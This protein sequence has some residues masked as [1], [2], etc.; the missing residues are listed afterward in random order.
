[1]SLKRFFSAV[2]RKWNRTIFCGLSS[3]SCTDSYLFWSFN[4]GVAIEGKG[5]LLPGFLFSFGQEDFYQSK[6]GGKH[7]RFFFSFSWARHQPTCQR[8]KSVA[9]YTHANTHTHKLCPLSVKAPIQTDTYM[10]STG[11]LTVFSLEDYSCFSHFT[12][13]SWAL[14][15]FKVGFNFFFNT[16]WTDWSTEMIMKTG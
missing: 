12:H 7:W 16:W 10:L 9:I 2:E 3:L 15:E 6:N 1:M 13:F 11:R 8:W 14:E 4:W 5:L